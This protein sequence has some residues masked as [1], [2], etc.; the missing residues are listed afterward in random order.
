M[1]SVGYPGNSFQNTY[2]QINMATGG[3]QEQSVS[4]AR[5]RRRQSTK[6][7]SGEGQDRLPVDSRRGSA[8]ERRSITRQRPKRTLPTA[9]DDSTAGVAGLLQRISLEDERDH[10]SIQEQDAAYT[11]NPE[12]GKRYGVVNQTLV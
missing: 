4:Q 7:Q 8:R 11:S 12:I 3:S 9:L 5:L 1:V 2:V 10:P 6:R